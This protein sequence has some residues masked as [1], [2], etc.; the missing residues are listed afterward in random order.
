MRIAILALSG[1]LLSGCSMLGFGNSGGTSGYNYGCYDNCSG[2]YSGQTSNVYGHSHQ[3]YASPQQHYASASS[4]EPS[5]YS[6]CLLYTS[7]SPRDRG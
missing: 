6:H 2:Q 3:D 5:Q 7:P 1:A 4:C